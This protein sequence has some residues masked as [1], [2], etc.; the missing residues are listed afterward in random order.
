MKHAFSLLLLA[1]FTFVS[2]R[3]A[4]AETVAI[5]AGRLADVDSGKMLSGQ[6]VLIEDGK[7]KA[8]G[9]DISIP[10][11]AKVID[12]S[13][14]TV[15]P[16]LIDC[17]THLVGSAD[18]DPIVELQKTSAQRAFE[19]IPNARKTI[20]AGFTTVRDV[21]CY[22]ALVDLALRDAIKRGDVV[23]PRMFAAGAYVTISKGGGALTG[24]APDITIPWDLH[25][26]QADN[27]WEVRKKVR[28]LAHYGVDLIKMIGTGAV[29]THG[30]NPGIEEFTPEE[31]QA[32]VD[33]AKR[34][35]LRVA[36]HAHGT[37]GVKDAIRAG[38]ASIEHGTC[39]DD[40]GI[41]LMKQHGTYLVADIYDDDYIMGE[42][43]DKGIPK[44]FQEHESNLGRIQRENFTKAVK[45]GVKI[46]YGTDAGVYPH[47]WNGKQFAYMVKYGLTPMQAIQ[48]ATIWASDLIG[49]SNQF[50][51]IKSGKYADLVAVDGDPLSDIRILEKVTFVMKEG[52]VVKQ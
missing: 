46:A 12:L 38:V 49:K 14:K 33:E 36:A 9:S 31:M 26:G 19:S 5:K 16:G 17:H 2:A 13:K 8:V 20:E 32:C 28:E 50:G 10:P 18:P 44:D 7:I 3:E 23:G 45:A 48:S 42:G 41:E 24:F 15:L 1:F 51:S 52:K 29:L 47:G 6:I 39:I 43:K 34:F 25:F 4:C 30:S 11:S 35:G 22:R 37:Q 21:G 27:P 40:E